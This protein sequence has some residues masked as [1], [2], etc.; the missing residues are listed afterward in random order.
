MHNQGLHVGPTSREPH[1]KGS[2]TPKLPR[3]ARPSS[4]LLEEAH[5][6]D[7]LVGSAGRSCPFLWVLPFLLWLPLG[8]Q[9]GLFLWSWCLGLG[10]FILAVRAG[11]ALVNL[12]SHW[13]EQQGRE[14]RMM[15]MVKASLHQRPPHAAFPLHSWEGRLWFKEHV[16]DTGTESKVKQ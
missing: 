1:E 10:E 5:D 13:W 11:F 3:G 7:L 8:G 2:N 16:S 6:G 15:M 4:F 9:Q 12:L 14:Q